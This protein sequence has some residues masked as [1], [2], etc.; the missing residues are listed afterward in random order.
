LIAFYEMNPSTVYLVQE[1]CGDHAREPTTG[2]KIYPSCSQRFEL[3][4]LSAVR[5]MTVPEFIERG[6]SNKID[7]TR[8]SP[9]EFGEMIESLLRF[10]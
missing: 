9:K 4:E 1:D 8:P 10:T 6:R 3:E 2:S 5:N 7:A